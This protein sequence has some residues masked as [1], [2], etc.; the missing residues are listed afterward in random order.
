M[1]VNDHFVCEDF[2]GILYVNWIS[3][4]TPGDILTCMH[5]VNSALYPVDMNPAQMQTLDENPGQL[6]LLDSFFFQDYFLMQGWDIT[7]KLE[8]LANKT[9][10][11]KFLRELRTSLAAAHASVPLLFLII[12]NVQ[13]VTPGWLNVTFWK[14]Y[15][16][17]AY[18]YK[19][20]E[21]TLEVDQPSFFD[22][23]LYQSR[24]RDDFA[25]SAITLT[26]TLTTETTPPPVSTTP[27]TFSKASR[28]SIHVAI[29]WTSLFVFLYSTCF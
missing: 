20:P 16:S 21:S 22:L 3:S 10:Q 9:S 12:R 23:D 14:A 1:C 27:I 15:S 5:D 8:P 24:L 7:L 11:Y 25:I 6:S 17:S 2:N 18:K 29:W 26:R 19:H 13:P 4:Q 28:V